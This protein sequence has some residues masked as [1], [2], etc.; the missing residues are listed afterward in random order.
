MKFRLVVSLL[1]SFLFFGGY[2]FHLKQ[3]PVQ[4]ASRAIASVQTTFNFLSKTELELLTSQER[5]D[6]L[7]EIAEVIVKA[8]AFKGSFRGV[9]GRRS[10]DKVSGLDLEFILGT[11]KAYADV[12]CPLYGLHP[13]ARASESDC[14]VLPEVLKI[15]DD[16]LDFFASETVQNATERSDSISV[17]KCPDGQKFCNPALLGFDFDE[18]GKARLRCLAEATNENCYKL[19]RT[20]GDQ[21]ERSLKVLNK[22]N[23]D[24]WREFTD[25]IEA[26]C[27]DSKGEFKESDQGCHFARKQMNYSTRKYRNKLNQDYL[28]LTAKLNQ[29]K[30]AVAADNKVC[31]QFTKTDSE[32][33]LADH[34]NFDAPGFKLMYKK[35]RCYRVPS[36]SVV[37]RWNDEFKVL[38]KPSDESE[39][40]SSG[41]A[42]NFN[43]NHDPAVVLT[44]KIGGLGTDPNRVSDVRF[45]NFQCG[46]CNDAKSLTACVFNMRKSK[47]DRSYEK[48][49]NNRFTSLGADDCRALIKQLETAKLPDLVFEKVQKQGLSFPKA[50]SID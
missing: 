19:K 32:L 2:Y 18:N 44:E 21:M 31:K 38:V 45:Y 40:L 36:S 1:F 7:N 13:Y 33:A 22:V 29:Q 23:P 14:G 43:P 9:Y 27:F 10:K 49:Q 28:N 41:S 48:I 35:G 42:Y 17:A 24:Y 11:S 30:K 25:G 12:Y 3:P 16:S 4:K 5:R 20:S 15:S 47:D 46:P 26:Q 50:K 37:T 34:E 39:K 6:Y 8:G